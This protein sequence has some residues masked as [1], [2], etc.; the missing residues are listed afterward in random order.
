V[1]EHVRDFFHLPP[2]QGH[3]APAL[4]VGAGIALPLLAV[5]VAGRLD[6][7]VYVIFGALTGVFG[8]VEPHGLRL[9]NLASGGTLMIAAVITGAAA[10]IAGMNPWSVV[11][12]GAVLSGT[13]SIVSDRLGLYPPGP[14]FHLFAFTTAAGVPCIASLGEVA[15]AALGSVAVAVLVGVTG[16]ISPR[17][18][19]IRCPYAPPH[20]TS[21]PMVLARAVLYTVAVGSAG[22]VAVT[23]GLGHYH[24]AMLAAT[25]PIAAVDIAGALTRATHSIVG[26]Y[27]GVALSAGL[28]AVD[29]TPLELVLLLA[30]LQFA[31]E[32][33]AVRHGSLALVFLTPVALMMTAFVVDT[34]AHQLIYDRLVETTIGAT[35]AIGCV[36]VAERLVS[37][38]RTS[39]TYRTCSAAIGAP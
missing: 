32:V 7:S 3:R 20:G 2:G 33:Y 37:R 14:F 10:S 17:R 19:G 11:A 22:G 5:L 31:G 39:R 21:R 25:A 27:V 26:T 9:K 34:P 38:V 36:I 28:L 30:L 6:L 29:W 23:V 24:W 13:F 12:A 18:Q 4:R 35:L 16:G 8:R 15:L 1:K